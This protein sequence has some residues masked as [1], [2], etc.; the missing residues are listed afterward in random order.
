MSVFMDAMSVMSHKGIEIEDT[1]EEEFIDD[2]IND[3]LQDVG[4]ISFYPMQRQIVIDCLIDEEQ[5]T[6][7]IK[8]PSMQLL[9]LIFAS[10]NGKIKK[11]VYHYSIG[12]GI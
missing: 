3:K 1:Q 4:V 10:G 5:K 11:S 8:E 12:G 2:F 6:Y 9:K 7:K